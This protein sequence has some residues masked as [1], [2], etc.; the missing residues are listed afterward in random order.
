VPE[1][2]GL[3]QNSGFEIVQDIILP[4]EDVP[5]EKWQ[6]ELVTLNYAAIL[7]RH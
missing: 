2:R 6:E 7:I 4:A 1:I 3:V 5:E